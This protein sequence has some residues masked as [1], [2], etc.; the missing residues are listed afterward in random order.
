MSDSNLFKLEISLD[1]KRQRCSLSA[2]HVVPITSLGLGIENKPPPSQRNIYLCRKR[3]KIRSLLLVYR[4]SNEGYRISRWEEVRLNPSICYDIPTLRWT[5][6]ALN[7]LSPLTFSIALLL[8]DKS[9]LRAT[10]GALFY[11]PFFSISMTSG[12]S[13]LFLQVKWS[14]WPPSSSR[15]SLTLKACSF[16]QLERIISSLVTFE[17]NVPHRL[18]NSAL[19][20][21]A[22]NQV[23]CSIS[24]SSKTFSTFIRLKQL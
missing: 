14:W 17:C 9:K 3:R 13:N 19:A 4:F 6:Q 15:R 11:S 1:I 18:R 24:P 20:N 12:R 7:K 22:W 10:Q 8:P 5:H 23:Q 2:F 21:Y 16:L